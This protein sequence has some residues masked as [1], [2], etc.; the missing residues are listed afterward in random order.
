[1]IA[2]KFAI[3]LPVLT[4]S[5][6]I[7]IDLSAL[8][9]QSQQLQKIA[10]ISA[11]T[12]AK[13]LSFSNANK[14]NVNAAIKAKI[15]H[16]VA[17]QKLSFPAKSI[18]I[19]TEVSNK[20]LQVSVHLKR[21]PTMFFYAL[22]KSSIDSIE[23]KSVAGIIGRPNICVL[24]LSKLGIG[25]ALWLSQR[26]K[27]TGKD[28]SIFSN[29]TLPGGIIV[30]DEAE[31]R[32]SAICSAGGFE[33]GAGHYDPAPYADCPQFED[34]LAHR[35]PPTVGACTSEDVVVK[36][37][38]RTL[39]PGTYCGGLVISGSSRVTLE[40]GIYV[41][42]DGPFI[43]T[44]TASLHGVGVS[45]Y[46]TGRNSKV[47]FTADTSIHLAATEDG[48]LAGLLFFGARNQSILMLNRIR[49]NDARH[50]IG[51]FYF[52]ASTLQVDAN[53]PVGDQSAYTAIVANRL[54]VMEGP[55]LVLNT[56][57]DKTDVPVPDG[58]RG[59]AQPIRLVQ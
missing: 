17:A 25:G 13:E 14:D 49:S 22:L 31:L 32:A 59:A 20:P 29:S 23:A 5:T 6:A 15:T 41:I 3:L 47:D 38:T 35:A 30:R 10:D 42:K 27:V 43:V 54:I 11:L 4:L 58:I 16:F 40:P 18:D 21:K 34:P 55:H 44:D 50:L 9:S 48:D 2:I 37:E 51:T 45:F 56:D 46:M 36:D 7:A 33:G 24:A 19:K 39:I 26:A 52:P 53:E 8:T 28:C 12:G 57:Y 1:M